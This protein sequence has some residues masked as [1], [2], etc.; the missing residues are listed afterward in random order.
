M[1]KRGDN[2]KI[3]TL[4]ELKYTEQDE[5]SKRDVTLLGTD[6]VF[7]LNNEDGNVVIAID[8]TN[9]LVPEWIIKKVESENG[10]TGYLKREVYQHI[11]RKELIERIDHITSKTAFN[12]KVINTGKEYILIVER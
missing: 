3:K 5:L 8:R 6:A 12:F 11:N 1:F 9:Y 10:D 2:V 4:N 7:L